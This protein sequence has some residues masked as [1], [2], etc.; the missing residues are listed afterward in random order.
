[1]CVES[2]NF[3]ELP[4]MS[5]GS[6]HQDKWIEGY[7]PTLLDSLKDVGKCSEKNVT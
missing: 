5:K 6:Y 4:H 2:W 1:M 7:L 3:N